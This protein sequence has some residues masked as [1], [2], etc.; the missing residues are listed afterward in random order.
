MWEYPVYLDEFDCDVVIEYDVILGDP[1]DYPVCPSCPSMIDI[2]D[3][4]YPD[5]TD[6]P[7]DIADYVYHKADDGWLYDELLE[8][9]EPSEPW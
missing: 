5:G 1:G 3:I 7:D 4:Y 9:A 8:N 6:V 2:A